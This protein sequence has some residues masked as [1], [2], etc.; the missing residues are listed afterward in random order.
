MDSEEGKRILRELRERLKEG[1]NL[2]GR[3][4]TPEKKPT[5]SSSAKP[6]PGE[7]SSSGESNGLE[8]PELPGRT[9]PTKERRTILE[10]PQYQESDK[11]AGQK[12]EV[13]PPQLVAGP[14][15]VSP[16]R[17]LLRPQP[18]FSVQSFPETIARGENPRVAGKQLGFVPYKGP[19]TLEEAPRTPGADLY[20]RLGEGMAVTQ[21]SAWHIP[22]KSPEGHDMIEIFVDFWR[23]KYKTNIFCI[24]VKTG[25][26]YAQK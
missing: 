15:D 9:E 8:P 13:H 22:D 26:V 21:M 1:L 6:N 2:Q 19:K 11:W 16:D 14:S 7:K 17:K 20:I 18:K 4:Q 24:D 12:S 23:E 5:S 10:V 25:Q 3:F